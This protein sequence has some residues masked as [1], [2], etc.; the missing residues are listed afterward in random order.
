VTIEIPGF[1]LVES[2]RQGLEREVFRGRTA[3]SRLGIRS[4]ARTWAPFMLN[5][6]KATSRSTGVARKR[7]IT[8]KG[9]WKEE[10]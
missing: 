9:E 7:T 6:L 1:V 2:N 5:I 3:T 4:Q 10:V 8:G